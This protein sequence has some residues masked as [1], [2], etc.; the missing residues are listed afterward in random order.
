[1]QEAPFFISPN[2]NLEETRKNDAA[3]SDVRGWSDEEGWREIAEKSISSLKLSGKKIGVDE[4]MTARFLLPIQ[5]FLSDTQFGGAGDVLSDLRMV[6]DEQEIESLREAG[7]KSDN[8]YKEALK[9]CRPGVTERQIASII[10]SAITNSGAELSFD[11][12]V[13]AGPNGAM[14]HHSPGNRP[15]QDGDIVILDLG[16][17]V[18]GYCGDI[19]RT[20]AIGKASDEATKVYDIVRRAYQSGVDSVKPG[21]SAESVDLA[22][23]SVIADAGY[24]EYFITRTGHGIGLDDHEHPNIVAGNKHLLRP[25]E[26]FSVEPGIYLPEKFGVR[27]ENIATVT[28]DAGQIVNEIPPT[29]ILV[30]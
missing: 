4:S 27:I 8:A 25:F 28:S 30:V 10:V 22:A 2:L 12:I 17:R 7:Q 21:I 15:F 18:D 20:I 1:L 3:I 13:A 14:P 24:G 26:A 5:N 23:R 16:A 29:D 9:H 6:K 11:P 19:T